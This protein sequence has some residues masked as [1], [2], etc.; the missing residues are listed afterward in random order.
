M[1]AGPSVLQSD[2]QRCA[3]LDDFAVIQESHS[4]VLGNGG[5]RLASAAAPDSLAL[6]IA[7]AMSASFPAVKTTASE[8]PQDDPMLAAKVGRPHPGL[9]N[10][11]G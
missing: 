4:G 6:S 5:F 2:L 10:R 8:R 7:G 9:V 11:I 3:Y 1:R